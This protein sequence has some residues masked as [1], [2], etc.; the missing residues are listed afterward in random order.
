M[1][2]EPKLLLCAFALEVDAILKGWKWEKLEQ[3]VRKLSTGKAEVYLVET[4]Q[5]KVNAALGTFE[6][7]QKFS[8]KEIL[9]IGCAGSLF[10][11]SPKQ[12]L[13]HQVI[14]ADFRSGMEKPP[15]FALST[16]SEFWN[17]SSFEKVTM[18][19]QDANAFDLADRMALH[20]E[21]Q[22]HLVAWESA[23]YARALQKLG[24]QGSE[25]RYVSDDKPPESFAAF[26]RQLL[27]AGYWQKQWFEEVLA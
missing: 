1:N 7:V 14:E 10:E 2:Q 9:W 8:P 12:G 18:A 17:L 26:K 21:F 5:G 15:R 6:A 16:E 27:L 3:N 19:S 13:V 25:L 22:A 4:G 23:G 24:I 11:D 20:E